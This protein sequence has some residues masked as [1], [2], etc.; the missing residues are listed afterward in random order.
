MKRENLREIIFLDKYCEEHKGFFH[1]WIVENQGN[2]YEGFSTYVY[3]LIET[4]EGNVCKF[5]YD[6]FTFIN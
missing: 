4:E 3:A 2:S 1:Q 5:A 6:E